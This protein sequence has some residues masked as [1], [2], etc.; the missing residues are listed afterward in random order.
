M[1]SLE[2]QLRLERKHDR[3]DP[4]VGWCVEG[5]AVE[6]PDEEGRVFEALQ[7]AS[8]RSEGVG[9]AHRRTSRH[10]REETA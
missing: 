7:Q 8:R 10:G 4:T 9:A 2:A 5:L 3:R 1:N 6:D